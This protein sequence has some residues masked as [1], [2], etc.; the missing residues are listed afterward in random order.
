MSANASVS[1]WIDRLKAGDA[2]AAQPLWNR[3][4]EHL[5]RL[6]YQRLR[7]A[8][9]AVADEEDVALSAFHSF[10]TAAEQG[11]FPQ[12]NDRDD[13]W[14][15]LVV[16]TERKALNLVRDQTR[17]KRGGGMVRQEP[18]ADGSA[19]GL[20]EVP[21][22]EPTPLFAALMAEECE[23]LLEQLEDRTLRAIAVE[24]MEGFDNDEIAARHSVAR[25][26]VERKLGLIRR[27]W[28]Q[29]LPSRRAAPDGNA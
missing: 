27:I 2:A 21:G 22:P 25:R 17:E 16:I 6:A 10:C 26:T 29:E 3:Y 1:F 18:P 7:G 12:L 8:P 5:V 19:P 20:A 23:R 13:L 28:E 11:R 4:F 24:K 15:L 14:R 9:R